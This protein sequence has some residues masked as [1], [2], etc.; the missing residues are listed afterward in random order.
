M[1][2]T[3]PKSSKETISENKNSIKGESYTNIESTSSSHQCDDMWMLNFLSLQENKYLERIQD[4]FIE[5]RF[6]FYGLKDK[7]DGFE[8]LYMV[9]QNAK[10][11]KNFEE[12]GKLYLYA[13][14][15]Y[16]FTK[17]GCESVLDRVLEKEFGSCP[18]YGCEGIPVI[19]I[20]LF[21]EYGKGK[22]KVYCHNCE[23][24]YEPKGSLKKLDGCAWGSG[25]CHFLILSYPYQFE[26]KKLVQYVP[27]LFGFVLSEL[28]DNDS[29]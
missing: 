13:H 21:N 29:G 7:L 22:S 28:D 25:F 11:S 18:K 27:K 14:Q 4:S 3:S 17:L 16:V 20:G 26:K 15:R 9:I 5:D 8:D 19:P 10:P 2:A 23:C 6:N 24:I 12:E 1:K